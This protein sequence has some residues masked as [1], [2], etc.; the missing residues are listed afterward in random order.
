MKRL[1]LF[2]IVGAG[3][4]RIHSMTMASLFSAMARGFSEI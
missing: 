2:R 4:T 3:E 1:E